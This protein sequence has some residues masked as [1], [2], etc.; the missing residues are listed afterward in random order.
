MTLQGGAEVAQTICSY[1]AKHSKVG[2]GFL[3]GTSADSDA[4]GVADCVEQRGRVEKGKAGPVLSQPGKLR[5]P[6]RDVKHLTVR[7]ALWAVI[8]PWQNEESK[9]GGFHTWQWS[10]ERCSDALGEVVVHLVALLPAVRNLEPGAGHQLHP[11]LVHKCCVLV[12]NSP[13][14]KDGGGATFL[15]FLHPAEYVL[16]GLHGNFV[17]LQ[18]PHFTLLFE[19]QGA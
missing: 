6:H 15:P 18:I 10:R 7:L 1:I 12:Q 5:S 3:D 19:H 4:L 9:L 2:L 11:V 14:W 17:N 13:R 8:D 16:V